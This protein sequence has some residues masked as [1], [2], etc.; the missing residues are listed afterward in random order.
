M[1][2]ITGRQQYDK[3]Q[4]LFIKSH[5]YYNILLMIIKTK[6]KILNETVTIIK[7]TKMIN[8]IEIIK[9]LQM[10]KFTDVWSQVCIL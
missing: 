9:I 4:Q 2:L 7:N 5:I 3:I 1:T 10:I 8:I 6:N